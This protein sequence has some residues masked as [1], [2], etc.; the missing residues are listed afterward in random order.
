V[1]A[2]TPGEQAVALDEYAATIGKDERLIVLVGAEGHGLDEATLGLAD[3][4]VRIPIDTAVD[5]LNV[6]VA[7]GIALFRLKAE[8]TGSQV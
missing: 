2:L 1:V 3:V 7:A 8:A 5:S 4:R 6:V